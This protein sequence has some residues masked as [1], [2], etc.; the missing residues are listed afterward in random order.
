MKL[1]WS[2]ER[3]PCL[4]TQRANIDS[5]NADGERAG[6]VQSAQLSCPTGGD[7]FGQASSAVSSN[8]TWEQ[9][10][11]GFGDRCWQL[12]WLDDPRTGCGVER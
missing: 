7:Y 8:A 12:R 9:L 4:E 11:S 10:T 3:V 5:T 2:S 6:V 1:A